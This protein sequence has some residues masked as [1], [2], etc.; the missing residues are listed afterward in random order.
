VVDVTTGDV[1]DGGTPSALSLNNLSSTPYTCGIS[2]MQGGKPNPL[3]AFPLNGNH[4][5]VIAPIE[6]I[7][8]M[9]ATQVN[10]TGT[11]VEQ[12]YSQGILID[13][14]SAQTRAVNYDIN[15]GWS[16]PGGSQGWATLVPANA[17]LIPLL[18]DSAS[19]SAFLRRRLR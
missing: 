15:A 10:N 18:I 3:C 4:M 12:A 9:F 13:L 7:L 11:V 6:K 14:T 17:Q 5:D 8:L 1:T 2:Q 19:P 16:T